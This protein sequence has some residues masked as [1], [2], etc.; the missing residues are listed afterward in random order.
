LIY[1]FE[2]SL[3]PHSLYYRPVVSSKFALAV[4][5]VILEQ[6]AVDLS[7]GQEELALP[8]LCVLL[9]ISLVLYPL[10]V[11]G[12]EVGVVETALDGGWIIVE[13]DAEAVELIVDPLSF[14]GDSSIGVVES[15]ESL[16]FIVL[17]LS[18]VLAALL[19]DELSFSVSHSVLLI[20]FVPCSNIIL[21]H[22]ESI[23]GFWLSLDDLVD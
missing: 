8:V 22:Y 12:V 3:M 21:L 18:L 7:V 9:Q 19:I 16:H 4:Y 5:K 14:V 6:T 11:E 1:L 17:P 15:A 23:L 2:E 10:L 13:D 20:A